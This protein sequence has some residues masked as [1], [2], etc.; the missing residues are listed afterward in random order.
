[1][2]EYP[3]TMVYLEDSL[4][5]VKETML[6][7]EQSQS[8]SGKGVY[9]GITWTGA[10]SEATNALGFTCNDLDDLKRMWII[11]DLIIRDMEG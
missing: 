3:I 9:I 10:I 5:F 11:L 2:G 6:T 7:F 8:N 4:E 1:M